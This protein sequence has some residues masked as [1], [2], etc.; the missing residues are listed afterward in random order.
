MRVAW[1]VKRFAAWRTGNPFLY[2]DG[3]HVF[4]GTCEVVNA[5]E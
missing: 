2:L 4:T 5:A 1:G 3:F